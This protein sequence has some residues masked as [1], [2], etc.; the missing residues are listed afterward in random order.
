MG[1]SMEKICGCEYGKI[2]LW[3]VFFLYWAWNFDYGKLLL[4][5]RFWL[6]KCLCWVCDVRSWM[7]FCGYV[8]GHWKF[9]RL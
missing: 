4:S 9:L 8:F 2:W 1:M 5:M 7:K 3:H 6:W